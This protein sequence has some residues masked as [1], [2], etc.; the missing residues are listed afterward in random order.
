MKQINIDWGKQIG[1]WYHRKE[2]SDFLETTYVNRLLN[3]VVSESKTNIVYPSLPL[4]FRA[5]RECS[6][7]NLK[8]VILGQD[9]YFDGS[10]NG[11]CFGN[12]NTTLRLSPS[13]SKIMER[14]EKDFN[15]L[16]IDEDPS[17]LY[18]AKQGVL[19]LNTALTV[20]KGL[21]KS[22]IVPWKQF[23]RFIISHIAENMPGTIFMLWGSSAHEFIKLNDGTLLSDKCNVLTSEHPAFASRMNREW[24]CNNFK[25]ANNILTEQNGKE[26]CIDW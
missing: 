9:P 17:L 12:D 4:I 8:I 3:F 15:V 19:L 24:Y 11:L 14:I 13:L 5:F 21:P 2:I 7:K 1:E 10:A 23:S 22:H 25:E 6:P 20:K 26:F 18:W 16:K